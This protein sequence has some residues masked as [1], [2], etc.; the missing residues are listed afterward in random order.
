MAGHFVYLVKC[1]DGTYYAGSAKN[2]E[3]RIKVHNAGRG[4]KYVRGRTPV[5]LVYSKRCGSLG[6]ALRREIA[7]KRLTRK[8]KEL[9]VRSSSH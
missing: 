8:E 4:A 3:A 6:S 2:V 9:L 7:I 1:A 5:R